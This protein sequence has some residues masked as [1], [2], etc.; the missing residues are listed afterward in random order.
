MAQ[1]KP[2]HTEARRLVLQTALGKYPNTEAL[3]A[4][5]ISSGLVTLDMQDTP[6]IFRA[7]AP[8]N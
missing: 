6:V 4:G 5:R 1:T 2:Y 3:H 7:F 8:S